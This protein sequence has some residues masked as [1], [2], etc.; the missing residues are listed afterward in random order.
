MSCIE[1][2][3]IEEFVKGKL[4]PQQMLEV[5]SHIRECADC[6]ELALSLSS[7]ADFAAVVTGAADCPEYEELSAYVDKK[8]DAAHAAAVERH[9][10]MCEFCATD[11]ARIE[12]LRS[13]ASMRDKITI[14][15]GASRVAKRGFFFYRRQA[16]A[17]TTVAGL[18]AVGF[19]LSSF[20]TV[21]TEDHGP[22]QIAANPP[23]THQVK[24]VLPQNPQKPIVPEKTTTPEP[25]KVAAVKTP[26][27]P[28]KI[29]ANQKSEPKIASAVLKDGRYSVIRRG[30]EL[31][32][33]KADGSSVRS[34]L[35]ARIAAKIDEKLRSGK[36][37]LPEPV[38][39]AMASVTVRSEGDGYD[40]PPAAP[41]PIGPSSKIVISTN[42]T[43]KW[44]PVDLAQAYRVR[45]YDD[46]GNVVGE[47]MTKD[48][49]LT[50]STPLARGKT[51]S[52][53]VG[54]RFGETDYWTQS[55]SV[56]FYVLSEQDFS[57]INSVRTRL[58]GSHLALGAAYE[59]AGLY[60]EAANEYRLLQ[61]ENP[62]SKL[63]K[64]LLNGVPRH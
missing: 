10:S 28:V 39:M 21:D 45:I 18:V 6:K 30:G 11:L 46:A 34:S 22:A 3:E 49:N 47:Q 51:Y 50:F 2:I 25:T 23:I 19:M 33:A 4:A 37:R 36:I 5:D 24:P 38:Q 58:R 60:E 8:L 53:R 17:V 7:R 40:V 12:E 56:P 52:W 29:A 63:A 62:N 32:L 61:R 55:G 64:D 1:R 15:P 43:F 20:N 9:A 27:T 35:E 14:R 16:L 26:P 54:V 57:S 41:K 31:T 48:T 13:H 59:S 44:A 42:P